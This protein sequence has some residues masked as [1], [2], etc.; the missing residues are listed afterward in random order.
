MTTFDCIVIGGGVVG[1]SAAYHLAMKGKK[2]LLLEQF[3][4]PHTRGSSHG[5]SRVLRTSY[6]KPLYSHMTVEALD[7]WKKLERQTNASLFKRTGVLV[8]DKTPYVEFNKNCKSVLECGGQYEEISQEELQRRYP[9]VMK[10]PNDYR[11]YVENDSGTLCADRVLSSLRKQIKEHGGQ[12]QDEVKVEHIFPGEIVTLKTNK[13]T[14]KT[15]H[16]II[17]AGTWTTDLLKPLGINLP[18][19]VERIT[20]CYWKEKVPGSTVNM[21]VFLDLALECYGLPSYEYKGLMK[22]CAHSGSYIT[23]PDQRDLSI[24]ERDLNFICRYIKDYLPGLEDKPSIVE[25]CMYTV[26]PDTDFVVDLL[27]NHPNI[28]VGAGFSGHGFKMAPVVGRILGE[29]VFGEELSYD[30]S[31]LSMKRFP[32]YFVS[33]NM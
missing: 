14:F 30:I 27:P 1:S 28:A 24:D 19:Q 22:V 18:L 11:F 31:S 21:P 7:I 10:L 13:G 4:L 33:A 2:T 6:D 29:L 25:S 12:I 8:L 20:V 23:H 3:P 9:G 15:E 26:T 16:L 32:K 17:T 5:A